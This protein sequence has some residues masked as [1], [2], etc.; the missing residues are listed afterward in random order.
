MHG[1]YTRGFT[2]AY[3]ILFSLSANA[4]AMRDLATISRDWKCLILTKSHRISRHFLAFSFFL[5]H[6]ATLNDKIVLW[7]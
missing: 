1:T 6:Q 7:L 3:S 4:E 5:A 2:T